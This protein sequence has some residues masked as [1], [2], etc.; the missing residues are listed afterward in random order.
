MSCFNSSTLGHLQRADPNGH[1]TSKRVRAV[2]PAARPKQA[3][4]S[5][6]VRMHPFWSQIWAR[7]ASTW[8]TRTS[9]DAPLL[10]VLGPG[11]RGTKAFPPLPPP[12]CPVAHAAPPFCPAP[13]PR[14]PPVPTY[15]PQLPDASRCP[16]SSLSPPGGATAS[17]FSA[18]SV[19]WLGRVR[20][21]ARTRHVR[22]FA[23][24][25][26]AMANRSYNDIEAIVELHN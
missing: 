2:G 24:K 15:C 7:N 12:V 20:I 13:P 16:T 5:K 25:T 19:G 8:T 14:P 9:D 3:V 1:R 6:R 17:P 21:C 22:P 11:G 18:P 26:A 10:S 23:N 4:L